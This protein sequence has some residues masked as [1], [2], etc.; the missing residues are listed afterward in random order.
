MLP[1]ARTFCRPSA[2]RATARVTFRV[3][4]SYPRRGDSWLK[5]MPEHAQVLYD[6]R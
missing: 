6:S 3:R 1:T 2:I 5:R 4:N